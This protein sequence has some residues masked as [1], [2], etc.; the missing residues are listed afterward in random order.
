MKI[1]LSAKWKG[2]VTLKFKDFQKSC[3]VTLARH[4]ES[5]LAILPSGSLMAYVK[6]EPKGLGKVQQLWIL[7]FLQGIIF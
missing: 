2:E 4:A 5:S 1:A 7:L 6:K 3:K